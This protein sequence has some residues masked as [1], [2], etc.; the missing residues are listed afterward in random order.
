MAANSSRLATLTNCF[1]TPVVKPALEDRMKQPML[2]GAQILF[3]AAVLTGTAA[4][5]EK[6]VTWTGWFGDSKCHPAVAVTGKVTV[7]NPDCTKT[8]LEK[9]ASP[10]FVSEQANAIFAVK[11]YP[12][13]L[14]DLGFHVEVQAVVDEAGKTIRVRGVKHLEAQGPSCARPRKK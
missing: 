3:L 13:V 9:G 2:L 6:P 7:T 1:Q 4:A 5:E 12:S 10:V 8:C 14:D 11:D